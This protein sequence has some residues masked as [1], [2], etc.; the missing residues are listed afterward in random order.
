M[1]LEEHGIKEE[2]QKF[3]CKFCYRKFSNK[4]VLGGHQN[5]HKLERSKEKN[6]RKAMSG[7]EYLNNQYLNFAIDINSRTINNHC[8]ATLNTFEGPCH[9][10]Q[11][12]AG[13]T[14]AFYLSITPSIRTTNWSANDPW[15]PS[16]IVSFNGDN[17]AASTSISSILLAKDLCPRTKLEMTI[18]VEAKN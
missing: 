10:N 3:S 5:A 17:F 6:A 9:P 13:P 12:L 1:K 8:Y 2:L 4:Q 16:R 14:N 11:G 7:E 18:I 15:M